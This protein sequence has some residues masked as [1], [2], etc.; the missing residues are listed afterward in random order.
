MDVIFFENTQNNDSFISPKRHFVVV[1]LCSTL[2]SW[3]QDLQFRFFYVMSMLQVTKQVVSKMKK[4][5]AEPEKSH[6]LV[7]FNRPY[8]ESLIYFTSAFCMLRKKSSVNL[9]LKHT[10]YLDIQLQIR[11]CF[12]RSH[13]KTFFPSQPLVQLCDRNSNL[14][15]IL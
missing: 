8:F 15:I 1:L 13:I 5:H 10:Y 9:F 3:K 7:Y 11:N 4:I 12:Q 6:F 2:H 14:L